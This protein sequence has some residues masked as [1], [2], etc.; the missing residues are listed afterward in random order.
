MR[1]PEKSF[2]KLQKAGKAEKDNEKLCQLGNQ[3]KGHGKLEKVGISCGNKET[4]PLLPPSN[5]GVLWRPP[6]E[7]VPTELHLQWFY[8]ALKELSQ[9]IPF[10]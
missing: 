9:N 4:D 7:A 8:T 1:K 3:K 2:W 6:Y 10:N 5:V